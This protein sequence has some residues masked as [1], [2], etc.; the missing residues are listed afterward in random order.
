MAMFVVMAGAA[1]LEVHR[2]LHKQPGDPDVEA[3]QK[4]EAELKA[5]LEVRAH[6]TAPVHAHS[7]PWRALLAPEI[8]TIQ[9]FK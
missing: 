7:L 2:A 5:A 1:A 6:R 9:S 3:L 4:R 8:H